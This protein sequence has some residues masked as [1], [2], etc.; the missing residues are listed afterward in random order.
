MPYLRLFAYANWVHMLIGSLVATS[1]NI[2]LIIYLHYFAKIIHVLNF[3]PHNPP[4]PP[5]S[6]MRLN[7]YY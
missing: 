6:F 5:F 1:H 4:P 3:S 7:L 2:A